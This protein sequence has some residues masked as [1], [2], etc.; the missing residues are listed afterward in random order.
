MK[1][2]PSFHS[3]R[4]NDHRSRRFVSR[5]LTL[6]SVLFVL[7]TGRSVSRPAAIDQVFD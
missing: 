1:V 2:R 5:H 4:L 3:S 6:L 7:T